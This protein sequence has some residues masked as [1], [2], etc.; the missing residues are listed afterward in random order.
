MKTIFLTYR[1]FILSSLVVLFFLIWLLIFAY[2]TYFDQKVSNYSDFNVYIVAAE[3]LKDNAGDRLYNIQTQKDYNLKLYDETQILTYKYPP[4][5]A[6]FFIPFTY[7]PLKLSFFIFNIISYF[8]VFIGVYIIGLLLPAVKKN[9]FWYLLPVST[10]FF[11]N[12]LA[13]GQVSA[14]T[15]LVGALCFYYF[16]HEKSYNLG[17]ASSLFLIKPHLALISLSLCLF[18]KKPIK[19]FLGL[20]I[21]SV[22]L[23]V[24]SIVLSGISF[25][26]D[27]VSFILKTETSD[28][29]ADQFGQYNIGSTLV[30][31][32]I[33]FKDLTIYP[34]LINI[35]LYILLMLTV[36]VNRFKLST[37]ALYSLLLVF[38]LLTTPHLW[39]SDLLL[40][41]TPWYL[42]WLISNETLS[43]INSYLR[44]VPVTMYLVF[45][46]IYAFLPL[47]ANTIVL[48]I[49]LSICL[50]VFKTATLNSNHNSSQVG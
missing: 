28:F 18:C 12:N 10:L 24:V 25:P 30:N 9:A 17:L 42:L 26:V 1:N 23:L 6:I 29:G 38:S 19:A 44:Y 27:Y 45:N 8:I 4:F 50:G 36:H 33:G 46:L 13:I 20:G 49:F 39:Y 11:S 2:K 37:N 22:I 14:F 7:L 16:K 43:G 40:L 34:I 35:F 31:S 41:V 15:F 47:L 3:I 48:G 5:V 21:A 32:L